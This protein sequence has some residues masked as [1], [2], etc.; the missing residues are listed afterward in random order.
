MW[1][2]YD[3][4]TAFS[5]QNYLYLKW[6]GNVLNDGWIPSTDLLIFARFT[7]FSLS[8]HY[9]PFLIPRHLPRNTTSLN[10]ISDRPALFVGKNYFCRQKSLI[11]WKNWCWKREWCGS[12]ILQDMILKRK[13]SSKYAS[14]ASLQKMVIIYINFYLIRWSQIWTRSL[15]N[16]VPVCLKCIV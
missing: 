4:L 7:A 8:L 10:E 16:T 2:K 1:G 14:F 11:N 12:Y 5:P 9:L 15:F 3:P 6:C 13:L